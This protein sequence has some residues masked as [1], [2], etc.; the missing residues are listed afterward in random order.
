[1]F[2]RLNLAATLMQK[3]N[4]VGSST[5][6]VLHR[7]RPSQEDD[8]LLAE[9]REWPDSAACFHMP[10]Q[11]KMAHPLMLRAFCSGQEERS[12]RCR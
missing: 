11:I 7:T 9:G 10:P 12:D 2:R 3:N 1:V 8:Q 6:Y 4:H 5:A